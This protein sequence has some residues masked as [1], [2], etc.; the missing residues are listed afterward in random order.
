[1]SDEYSILKKYQ[2]WRDTENK[3]DYAQQIKEL[4]A[5]RDRLIEREKLRKQR[6]ANYELKHPRLVK[7]TK[8]AEKAGSRITKFAGSLV[9]AG[10]GSYSAVKNQAEKQRGRIGGGVRATAQTVRKSFQSPDG[11]DISLSSAIARNSWSDKTIMDV[12]FFGNANVEKN[13]LGSSYKD[14]LL[15]S[16]KKKVVEEELF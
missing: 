11:N 6:A 5:E 16:D 14:T 12:D 15:I 7:T 1:M 10:A 8:S 2:S 3:T 9:K 13:I 4:R